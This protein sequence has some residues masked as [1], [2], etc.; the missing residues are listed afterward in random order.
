MRLSL[1]E[2]FDEQ[3]EHVVFDKKL[4]QLLYQY[5]FGFINRNREHLEFFG[6][7]L[8]GVQ[9]IRFKDSDVNK[10][11]NEVLDVDYAALTEKVRDVSTIRHDYKISGDILNLTLMYV[12]HRCLTS[13]KMT[14]DLRESAALNAALIFFYRCVCALTSDWFTYPADE[15]I[16]QR[17][18][19]NLSNKH[20][21]KKLG[22]WIKVMEYRAKDLIDKKGLHRK[23]LERFVDDDST[24][25]AIND[26]QG[27]IKDLMKNYY[28]EFSIVHSAG[29]NIAQT[30]S[31]VF[32][33]DGEESLKEKT[34]SADSFVV[35]AR[36]LI[37]DPQGFIRDDI[38]EVIV[39]INVNTSFRTVKGVLEWFCKNYMDQK[40]HKSLDTFL[41]KVI[42]QTMHL[43]EY[44][45]P[46]GR[47]KDYAYIL[48]N[49]KN[50]YLSTRSTDSD[51][52]DI[53]SLGEDIVVKANGKMSKSLMM[54]TRLSLILYISLR[55]LV[56]K[57][58]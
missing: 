15:K 16:A 12:V 45:I 9:V 37:T 23:A 14:A 5:Q 34:K 50:L 11:Y 43:I 55:V 2:A 8:L 35:H 32:D 20:L 7:N 4:A 19:A 48:Q 49:L 42:M 36:H 38:I 10:F 1:K 33:I 17:A 26:S 46:L 40:E 3:F 13:V 52:A 28:A 44:N 27:R 53:R 58:Y 18:F 31:T 51:L 24:V 41:E 54:A 22:S 25:Y 57:G 6:G 21:I 47:R 30:S 29:E 39:E 56:S